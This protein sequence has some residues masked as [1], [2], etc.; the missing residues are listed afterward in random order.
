MKSVLAVVMVGA[1]TTTTLAMSTAA[2]TTQARFI[3]PSGAA[4]STIAWHR[5]GVDVIALALSRSSGT[6]A[7]EATSIQLALPSGASVVG[8]GAVNQRTGASLPGRWRC[9]AGRLTTC[10][11]EG[12]IAPKSFLAYVEVTNHWRAAP[13]ASALRVRARVDGARATTLRA[14]VTSQAT[15]IPTVSLDRSATPIVAL[16]A[17]G[18]V[19]YQ[20]RVVGGASLATSP[21]SPAITFTD[22]LP[23]L[24]TNW[25]VH[26]TSWRCQGITATALTCAYVGPSVAVG[27]GA[28][29]LTLTYRVPRTYALTGRSAWVSWTAGLH[30]TGPYGVQLARPV[31][32]RIDVVAGHEGTLAVRVSAVG[33]QSVARGATRTVL[34]QQQASDGVASGLA[35]T[36]VVPRGFSLLGSQQNGWTCPTGAGT[37]T[38][39]HP[40]PITTNAPVDLALTLR[41]SATAPVGMTLVA[42]VAAALDGTVKNAGL[43]V[44]NVL[45]PRTS[46]SSPISSPSPARSAAGAAVPTITASNGVD[47]TSSSVV[48]SSVTSS[49]TRATR[50]SVT[51]FAPTAPTRAARVEGAT[52]TRSHAPSAAPS[53]LTTC[54]STMPTTLGPFTVSISS[55]TSGTSGCTGTV[56]LTLGTG[57]DLFSGLTLTGT[58]NY[59]DANDWY[60]TLNATQTSITFFGA[61]PT[62]AGTIYDTAGV[63]SGSLSVSLSGA[64][65]SSVMSISGSVTLDVPSA[66]TIVASSSFTLAITGTN[67]SLSF[68]VSLTY[69]NATNWSVTVGAN[70]QLAFDSISPVDLAVTGTISDASGSLSGSLTAA[71]TSPITIVPSVAIT[72]SLSFAATSA[73]ATFSG[74]LTLTSG[75]LTLPVTFTYTDPTDWSASLAVSGDSSG[76]TVA[77]NVTIPISSLSGTVSYGYFGGDV[78]TLEWSVTASLSPIT[79]IANV[80]TLS[81]VTLSITTCPA[82][83]YQGQVTSSPCPTNAT[84]TYVFLSGSLALSF[85][86]L[87]SQSLTFSANVNLATGGFDLSASMPGPITVVSGVLSISSPTLEISYNDPGFANPGSNLSLNGLG[88]AGGFSVLIS[89]TATLSFA[90]TTTTIPVSLVFDSAGLAVVADFSP[91]FALGST[92]AS[93]NVVAFTTAAATMTLNGI[94]TNVPADTFVLG[95]SISLP[96][97]ITTYLDLGSS[98]SVNITVLYSS[99][100]DFSLTATFPESVSITASPEFAFTFGDLSLSIGASTGQG[101]VVS[102]SESGTLTIKGAAAGGQTRSRRWRSP[103]RSAINRLATSCC[104]PSAARAST[105]RRCGRTP[106][107]TRVWTSTPWAFKRVSR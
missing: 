52:I 74:S 90:G 96:S 18:S 56:S 16:G 48:P 7:N 76:Y 92:G 24:A 82:P 99:A 54:P 43:A 31:P 29:P 50:S 9:S 83:T 49:A 86:G 6:S 46:S 91:S 72:G 73:S 64:T 88:A 10:Q 59:T 4:T 84:G 13:R 1:T 85:P 65:L 30:V 55:L 41:A 61:T 66:T 103:W 53:P 67:N 34:V 51:T 89:A 68:P 47:P 25:R 38:C 45:G 26:S 20:L 102:L 2:A 94:S 63:F 70:A 11:L 60:I 104:S 23:A 69:S 57:L 106:S 62:F 37:L 42:V 12:T 22:P 97:Y 44:L 95:G 93:I 107:A 21:A 80:A 28:A 27:A 35:D 14:S 77:P 105:V 58:V 17:T 33:S 32:G 8:V 36:V 101:V 98:P 15:N 79:L 87:S 5:S 100:S 3:S 40:S 81:S 39:R 19:S 78:P 71:T 75:Q